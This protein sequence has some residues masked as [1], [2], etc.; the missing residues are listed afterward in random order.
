MV[1]ANPDP[2]S[3]GQIKVRLKRCDIAK[4]HYMAALRTLAQLRATLR[5]GM[6]P[7][8]P[9]HLYG[10]PKDRKLA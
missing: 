4:K 5:H 3:I 8:S 10:E 7:T 1:L 2:A 9:L 6:V